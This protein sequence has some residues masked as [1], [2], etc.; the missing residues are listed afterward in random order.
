[1]PS[2]GGGGAR[3]TSPVRIVRADGSSKTVRPM[4]LRSGGARIADDKPVLLRCPSGQTAARATGLEERNRGPALHVG[5][6][7]ECHWKIA[8]GVDALDPELDPGPCR[9]A[10]AAPSAR[11][12]RGRGR[13]GIGRTLALSPKKKNKLWI[14]LAFDRTG[15]RLVDWECGAR[16]AATLTRL[17]ERL[18]PWSVKLYCTDD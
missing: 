17:L 7:Y 14:W 3:W 18:K 2:A 16:D 4:V 11:A 13:D 5:F 10:R 12:G 1:M 9:D 6:V 15:Q 8:G